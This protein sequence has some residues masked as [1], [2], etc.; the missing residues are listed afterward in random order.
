MAPRPDI[1]FYNSQINLEKINVYI[2]FKS[3]LTNKPNIKV[4]ISFLMKQISL[5]LKNLLSTL[6]PL[7]QKNFFK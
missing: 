1:K 6:S 4:F 5:K 7:V 2:D 3:L